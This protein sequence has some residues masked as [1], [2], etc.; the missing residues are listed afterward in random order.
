MKMRHSDPS[1]TMTTVTLQDHALGQ[2]LSRYL[3]GSLT[4]SAL[5]AVTELFEDTDA[6]ATERLAFARFYLDALDARETHALPSAEDV[7]DV[8]AAARAPRA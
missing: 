8:L 2:L 5:D 3:S 7:A 1:P 4:A 6:S